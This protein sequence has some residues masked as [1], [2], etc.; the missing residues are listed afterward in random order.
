MIYVKRGLGPRDLLICLYNSD[1]K[2]FMNLRG[3]K[4]YEH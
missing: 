2:L 4:I 3:M 1:H